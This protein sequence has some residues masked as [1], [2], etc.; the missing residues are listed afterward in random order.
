MARIRGAD[1][2]DDSAPRVEAEA[3]HETAC[4]RRGVHT[5]E[6]GEGQGEPV[7]RSR[8]AARG[9]ARRANTTVRQR[10]VDGDEGVEN[11]RT[12][13]REEPQDDGVKL[14]WISE[15]QD[16]GRGPFLEEPPDPK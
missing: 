1:R 13:W 6:I 16:V 5:D 15:V 3:L 11:Q 2:Y 7:Q 4:V 8:Q 10:L 9:A 14:P 12:A